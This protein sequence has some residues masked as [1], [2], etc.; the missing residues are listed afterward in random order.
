MQLGLNIDHIAT[1]RQARKIA[2][3]DP[4]EAVFVAANCGVDQITI[5]L[6]EDRRHIQD[7]D[8]RSIIKHSPLPIN[9][10][11]ACDVNIVEFLC[12]L[13]PFKITLVPE[14]REE[15]TTEGG[16]NMNTPHLKDIIKEFHKNHI[17]VATFIDPN[18]QSLLLSKEF[19]ANGVELHTGEYANI[20]AM[21][22]SSLRTHTNKIQ[23]LD[24]SQTELERQ[25]EVTITALQ[26]Y[27]NKANELKLGVFA[28]HGLNYQNIQTIAKIPHITELNI[29]HSII[30]RAVIVGLESAICQMQK[31]LL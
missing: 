3:P 29:G 27:A 13:K 17:K 24:L 2:Q 20:S 12:A 4:L 26:T 30:A 16:L 11:C 9:V 1:L 8:V 15:I 22:Y 10:E 25:L 18:E 23:S 5:H 19:N 21:L 31:L 14:K 28:G 6:R 7:E